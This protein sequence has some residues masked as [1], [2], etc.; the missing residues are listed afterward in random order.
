M[1]LDVPA[2][3]RRAVEGFGERVRAVREQDWAKPTPC[4]GWDVRALVNHLVYEDRWTPEI[5]AGR[6]ISE[7][8]DRFE[9]DLLGENPQ[10]AW[11]SASREA[12]T[13]VSDSGALERVVHL[14]FGDFP[15][16][17]YAM[18]L[19]ADHLIHAWDLARGIGGDGR[20]DPELVEVCAT[21]FTPAVERAY[22]G[23]GAIGPRIDLADGADAQAILLARFGR[24]A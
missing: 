17:E 18:Q 16:S 11:S 2:L 24:K 5:F 19:F 7:V 4:G 1:A 20:L 13:A 6:T 14:S 10:G 21:W 22:R 3:H 12:V 9:G 23:T 8:G 15:G